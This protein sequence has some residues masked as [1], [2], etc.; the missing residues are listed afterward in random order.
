ME[1]KS[2]NT[3]ICGNNTLLNNQWIKEITRDI[4]KYLKT[5]EK[6]IYQNI[7]DIV[8]TALR[9][10]FV[11]ISVYI[12]KRRKISNQQPNFASLHNVQTKTKARKRKKI[13]IRVEINK[14]ENRK[15][16]E[17]NKETKHSLKRSNKAYKSSCSLEKKRLKLPKSKN[18][19]E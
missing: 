11:A 9:G 12:L 7:C 10:K 5:N 17:K 6:T 3:Q 19:S 15:T 14:T 16:I 18:Q 8:K 13:K 1:G 4:R 2:E